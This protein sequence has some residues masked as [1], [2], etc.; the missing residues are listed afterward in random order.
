MHWGKW[1]GADEW[2]GG[3][4]REG[5]MNG[6][7]KMWSDGADETKVSS[8]NYKGLKLNYMAFDICNADEGACKSG[9]GGDAGH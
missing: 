7:K 1:D 5:W 3:G 2:R 4:E 6:F 9:R 8:T